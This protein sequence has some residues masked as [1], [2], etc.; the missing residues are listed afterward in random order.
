MRVV[1]DPRLAVS[2]GREYT[3][4]GLTSNHPNEHRFERAQSL[5]GACACTQNALSRALIEIVIDA[6]L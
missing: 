5:G 3:S 1:A 2:L 6:E 4:E